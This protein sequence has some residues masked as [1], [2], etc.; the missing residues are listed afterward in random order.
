M[1]RIVLSG[2]DNTAE[3]MVASWISTVTALS[4]TVSGYFEG[5]SANSHWNVRV[6]LTEVPLSAP[7][8]NPKPLVRSWIRT[9]G[10]WKGRGRK[11]RSISDRSGKSGRGTR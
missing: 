10:R 9:G 7:T 4:V 6:L 2:A 1:R 5:A 11:V 8:G 3:N